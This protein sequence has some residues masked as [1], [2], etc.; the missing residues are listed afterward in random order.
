MESMILQERF[1]QRVREAMALEHINQTELAERMGV[2]RSLVS[3]YLSP[4]RPI[5]PGFDMVE[6]FARALQLEDPA[7]LVS[8][9][10]ICVVNT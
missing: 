10:E 8:A 7:A 3:Q 4:T 6:K 9:T 2:T 5:S 1:A